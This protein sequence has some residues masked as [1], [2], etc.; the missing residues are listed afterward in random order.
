MWKPT[1][2]PRAFLAGLG[3]ALFLISTASADVILFVDDGARPGGGGLSWDS[4]YRFLQDAFAFA[5]DPD[6]DVNEIRVGQGIYQPDRNERNPQGTGQR[7]ATYHLIN[8]VAIMGGFA[9]TGADDPDAHDIEL[10]ET[11]LSG[12]LASNDGPPGS[13]ENN[14]EN[15]YHVVTGSK[16]NETAI[17]DGFVITGGNATDA[18]LYEFG[19]GVINLTGSPTVNNCSLTLNAARHGA[20]MYNFD[21]SSPT[22]TNC[23]F[24]GNVA[25]IGSSRGGGMY[26]ANGSSPRISNCFF[27]ENTAY[28]GGGL[29]ARDSDLVF[30]DCTFSLNSSTGRG[31]AVNLSGEGAPI[32]FGCIFEDNWAETSGGA[33]NISGD[34]SIA[35]TNCDFLGNSASLNGGAVR[36]SSH[37][38]EFNDCTFTDNS[39]T[40]NGGALLINFGGHT[41]Y[42]SSFASN[43]AAVGGAMYQADGDTLVSQG[44]FS[45]NSAGVGGGLY[46]VEGTLML[47]ETTL[48]E[49]EAIFGGAIYSDNTSPTLENCLLDDNYAL[50]EGGGLYNEMG[51]PSLVDCIIE[52]NVSLA[53]G[54]GIYNILGEVSLTDC[55]VVGN[56]A[57]SLGAGMYNVEGELLAVGT[58]FSYN[59]AL[60]GGGLYNVQSSPILDDCA[61]SHNTA[62][63][64]GG[65]MYN[66]DSNLS[67][68]RCTFTDNKSEWDRGGAIA[69]FSSDSVIVSST[70]SDNDAKGKGGAIY[71][72]SSTLQILNCVFW[73]NQSFESGGAIFNFSS[74][75]TIT[76]A[77]FNANSTLIGFGGAIVND[78]STLAVV[79]SI[80]WGDFPSEILDVQEP[81]SLVSYS[82]VEGGW[83]GESNIDLNPIFEAEVPHADQLRLSPGSPCIDAGDNLSVPKGT[84]FDLDGNPRFVDDPC[85]TDTG[86]GDAPIVDMGAYEFQG[87]SCDLSGD[88]FVGTSDL[89]ILI[90]SWGRCDECD[91]CPADFDDNCVV[92]A[93]DLLILLVNWG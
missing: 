14:D 25:M 53:D 72:E 91:D 69:N 51:S 6:Q 75:S 5:S 87:T 15:S 7:E 61:F 35:L 22:V 63:Y 56:F 80:L 73:F 48:R 17:I 81:Q 24:S 18:D 67:F 50:L 64:S 68:E 54:G 13:F 92:G 41:L 88:G 1:L 83:V 90:A 79:N 66:L 82:N 20:G 4:A 49:N 60:G 45:S 9:G 76:N 36:S 38:A 59:S 65:G 40:N 84:E 39:A 62:T 37:S 85:A 52:G 89:L 46:V 28:A 32:I 30:V 44:T 34:T 58:L 70:F 86:G 43:T 23:T 26:N 27:S 77:T 2:R 42:N 11:T 93:S 33:L 29:Y 71:N 74:N 47:T 16:T 78:Q 21:N 10:Y 55:D 31:G 3:T 19:G 12:D 8:N 57:F